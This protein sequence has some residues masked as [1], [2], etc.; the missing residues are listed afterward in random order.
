MFI[1]A[2][3]PWRNTK[4]ITPVWNQQVRYFQKEHQIQDPGIHELF[5]NY[6]CQFVGNLRDTGH[7]IILGMDANSDIRR[8]KRSKALEEISMFKAILKFLKDKSPPATCTTNTNCKVIDSFWT[9]PGIDI[10]WFGFFLFHAPLGF[11]SD[12]ILIC[13]NIWNQFL[14]G[15]RLQNIFRAPASKVKN[16]QDGF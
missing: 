4:G 11:D 16:T 5:D 8:G 9:S 7:N 14:Y 13:S 3:R 10:L 12:H 15:H 2:Y 6:L 1:S